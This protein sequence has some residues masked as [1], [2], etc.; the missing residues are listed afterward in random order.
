MFIIVVFYQAV[1]KFCYNL[2]EVNYKTKAY[3][4]PIWHDSSFSAKSFLLSN[5]HCCR[6]SDSKR[7]S[8]VKR[9]SGEDSDT[10]SR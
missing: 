1:S 9:L 5:V 7:L 2:K 3:P 10:L 4:V 6:V 8:R